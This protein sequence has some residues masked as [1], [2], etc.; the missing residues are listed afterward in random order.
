[1]HA[2]ANCLNC[3]MPRKVFVLFK[4]HRS[5]ISICCFTALGI[6]TY[7]GKCFLLAGGVSLQ[8]ISEI[9]THLSREI[10]ILLSIDLKIVTE[11]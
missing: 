5:G 2:K 9:A 3:R 1:M 4:G 7:L 11:K 6:M 10:I 8:T